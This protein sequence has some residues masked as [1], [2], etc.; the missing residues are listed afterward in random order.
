MPCVLFVLLS[1]MLTTLVFIAKRMRPDAIGPVAVTIAVCLTSPV[2]ML[3]FGV[4]TSSGGWGRVYRPDDAFRTALL[5][6]IVM[7]FL[8]MVSF[9]SWW[10]A[11][12][13]IAGM[14][15][16]VIVDRVF[17]PTSKDEIQWVLW[18]GSWFCVVL[19]T[20]AAWIA[21][22]PK[23]VVPPGPPPTTCT[24]CG[25]SF[26]GLPKAAPCP[27]CGTGRG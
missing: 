1:L 19:P 8:F 21:Y 17:R 26:V 2:W 23:R 22:A 11:L 14:V 5:P 24:R 16:L 12:S 15:V 3:V 7:A 25:Y 9:R 18:A 10:V 27:E 13:P 6:S 20:I 4:L